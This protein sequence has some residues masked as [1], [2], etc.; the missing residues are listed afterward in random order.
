MADEITKPENEDIETLNKI[1]EILSR[2]ETSKQQ[3]AL[4]QIQATNEDN[5]RQ[6]DYAL[7]KANKENQKWHKSMNIASIAVFI[8]LV[9]SIY[10]LI[11]DKIDIGLGLLS[12]TL[13]GVFGYLAGVGSSKK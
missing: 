10:F 6:Y 1:S 9:I 8:L 3:T 12:T 5:K 11:I 13:A 2:I 7:D 4:A